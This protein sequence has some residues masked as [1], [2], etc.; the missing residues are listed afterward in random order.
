VAHRVAP[1]FAGVTGLAGAA[2]AFEFLQARYEFLSSIVHH[3]FRVA[4]LPLHRGT[5]RHAALSLI[6]GCCQPLPGIR[7]RGFGGLWGNRSRK[8]DQSLIFRAVSIAQ[9]LSRSSTAIRSS[10]AR[11]AMKGLVTEKK[12]IVILVEDDLSVLRALRRLMTAAGFEVR[13]SDRPSAVLT[14]E[15]PTSRACLVIDLYLPEMNG[16]ELC[17]TLAVL[18]CHLP[19]V[20]ITSHIE[21]SALNLAARANPVAVLS[22]PFSRDVLLQALSAAIAISQL[23]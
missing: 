22:K 15:L 3:V 5:E 21:E 13:A 18:G 12:P 11:E 23:D 4:P 2:L 10:V 14:N 16:V 8:S 6:H 19:V 9:C 1:L 20:M 17:E 7:I